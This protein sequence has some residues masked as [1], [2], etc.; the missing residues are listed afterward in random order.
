MKARKDKLKDGKDPDKDRE[1]TY[2]A[3]GEHIEGTIKL[4]TASKAVNLVDSEKDIRTKR[5]FVSATINK[6]D[7][8]ACFG[9]LLTDKL[10]KKLQDVEL[11]NKLVFKKALFLDRTSRLN[12]VKKQRDQVLEIKRM[13]E[14]YVTV[15]HLKTAY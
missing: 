4:L 5:M 14:K 3:Y 11:Y 12:I 15:D 7:Q 8:K 2:I 6:I 1:I 9:G 10:C 13:Q